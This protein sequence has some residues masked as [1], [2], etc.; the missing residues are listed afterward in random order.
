MNN[1]PDAVEPKI[2]ISVK[3]WS[4]S[5]SSSRVFDICIKLN[6]RE[7]KDTTQR[8]GVNTDN[9]DKSEPVGN[10]SIV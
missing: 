1:N 7:E 8:D 4:P 6:P 5:F 2:N 3:L 9:I 10:N